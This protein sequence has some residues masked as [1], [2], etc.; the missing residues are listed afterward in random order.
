M[1]LLTA[2]PPWYDAAANL[3]KVW[4][5]GQLNR[6][7]GSSVPGPPAAF[8][9]AL[10]WGLADTR[11]QGVP[12]PFFGEWAYPPARDESSVAPPWGRP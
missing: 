12:G 5:C 3:L 6:A 8:I 11:A 4:Y 7:D 1:V 2:N 9:N 10:V